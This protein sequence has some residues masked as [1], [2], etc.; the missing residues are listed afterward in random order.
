MRFASSLT[1]V[2]LAVVSLT[3]CQDNEEA[4]VIVADWKTCWSITVQYPSDGLSLSTTDEGCDNKTLTENH[5][6][7]I[8]FHKISGTGLLCVQFHKTGHEMRESCTR[9]LRE[10]I[11]MPG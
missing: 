2:L 6:Q 10:S 5:V 11:T 8:T 1:A 7:S 3:G 4:I 9:Q